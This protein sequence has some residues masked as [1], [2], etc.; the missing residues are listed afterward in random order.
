MTHRTALHHRAG[1]LTVHWAG[2]LL[3]L[4]FALVVAG[5]VCVVTVIPRVTGG[6]AL[7]VLSGSMTP[8]IPV[9][10][11][12]VV[13][14]VDPETLQVGDVVTYQ[15]E[16]GR[17]IYITHR[18]VD[19][20][21]GPQTVFTFKGDANRVP[22]SAPVVSGQVRGKVWFHVPYLGTIRDGLKKPGGMLLVGTMLLAGYAV[23]QLGGGLKDRRNPQPDTSSAS[24]V[25]EVHHVDA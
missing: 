9:G 10:S 13:R 12:V 7:T 25:S 23:A 2:R 16:P 24:P 3:V 1:N 20:Q 5:A 18:V 19:I 11:V 8:G 4:L 14:P 21:R 17:P 22:D 15:V 6:Q